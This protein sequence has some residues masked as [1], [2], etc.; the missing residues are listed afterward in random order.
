MEILDEQLEQKKQ[1]YRM[2]V[3][4]GYKKNNKTAIVRACRKQFYMP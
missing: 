4:S 1:I 2:P 3:H